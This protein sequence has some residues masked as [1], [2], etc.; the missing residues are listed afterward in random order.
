VARKFLAKVEMETHVRDACTEMVMFFHDSTSRYAAKFYEH[1]K[2][3]YY[4]TPTSYLEMIIT[5]QNLLDEKRKEV[6]AKIK[7]YEN[8]YNQIIKTEG[9]VSVM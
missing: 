1:L 2:R 8:G 7:K 9:E 3:K 4:V 5:F 6:N